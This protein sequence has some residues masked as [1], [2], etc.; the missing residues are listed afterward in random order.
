MKISITKKNIKNASQSDGLRT[1]VEVSM[2]ELD[3]FEEIE[4]RKVEEGD[5]Y[6]LLDGEKVVLP[7]IVQEELHNWFA[8]QKMNPVQFDISLHAPSTFMAD[9]GLMMD[10]FDDSFDTDYGFSFV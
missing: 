2:Q 7:S 9:D 5:Y 3:C 8:H 6:L 4:L 10:V 1:P